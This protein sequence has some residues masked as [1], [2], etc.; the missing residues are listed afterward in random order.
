[1]RGTDLCVAPVYSLDEALA[2]PHN[3]HR[4]MVVDVEAPGLGVVKQVGIS[5]KL[6]ETPGQVR[7]VAPLAGQQT[8]EVLEGLGY[9]AAEIAG[10]REREVVA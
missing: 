3:R 10:L 5:V 9:G 1:M 6:S 4:Q 2:D 7:Q 8:D